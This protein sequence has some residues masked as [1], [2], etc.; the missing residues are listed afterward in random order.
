MRRVHACACGDAGGLSS[1]RNDPERAAGHE[2]DAVRG[3]IEDQDQT[4]HPHEHTFEHR[5]GA[6][7]Q[8]A[9][10]CRRPACD[11]KRNEQRRCGP[12]RSASPKG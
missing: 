11:E 3:E 2:A 1:L 7:P 6:L 10:A 8:H 9:Q 12:D 5:C 4:E